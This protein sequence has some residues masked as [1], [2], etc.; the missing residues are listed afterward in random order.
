[1]TAARIQSPSV[2]RGRTWK[3]GPRECFRAAPYSESP[4]QPVCGT[5]PHKPRKSPETQENRRQIGA[6]VALRVWQRGNPV[7]QFA[8]RI[9][10][11]SGIR[12]E[13]KTFSTVGI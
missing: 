6:G 1:M 7:N 3:M 4:L 2:V 12:T 5:M 9:A 11:A 13:A 8:A 10:G